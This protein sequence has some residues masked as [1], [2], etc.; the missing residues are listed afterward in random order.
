MLKLK[1]ALKA[2]GTPDFE[3]ALKEDI[4]LLESGVLPL[5]QGLSLSSHVADA[6]ISVIV[7]NTT[8]STESIRAKTGIFY[9]GIIAGSCCADDPTPVSEN[10]E[11]CE[12]LFEINK[13]TAETVVTLLQR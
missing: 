2:L 13:I 4:Q 5:Q 9:A 8:E 12:L 10:T 1:N 11:Y 7:L 6:K 3:K